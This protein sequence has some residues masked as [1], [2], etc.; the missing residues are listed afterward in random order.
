MTYHQLIAAIAKVNFI[1]H[2]SRVF[3]RITQ[4][5]WDITNL[6]LDYVIVYTPSLL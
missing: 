2:I 1:V 5:F 3:R 6:H 4:R